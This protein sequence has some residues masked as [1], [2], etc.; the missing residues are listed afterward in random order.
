M[1]AIK[2][3]K[4]GILTYVKGQHSCLFGCSE[5]IKEGIKQGRLQAL[6]DVEKII[7]EIDFRNDFYAKGTRLIIKS[8]IAKLAKERK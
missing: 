8:A 7:D 6:N 2:N 1:K 4:I 3:H 5:C